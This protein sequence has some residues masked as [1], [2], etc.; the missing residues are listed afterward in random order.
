MAP[1]HLSSTSHRCPNGMRS[2]ES[3]HLE[4]VWITGA[5]LWLS[6]MHQWAFGTYEPVTS[7]FLSL[8]LVGL[9]HC[10]LGTPNETLLWRSARLH[11]GP[12]VKV[13]QILMQTHH[14]LF[15]THQ[16]RG[17][18]VHLWPLSQV[19]LQWDN[20]CY[21]PRLSVVMMVRCVVMWLIDICF[22]TLKRTS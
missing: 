3:G 11:N 6:L 22:D 4:L 19:P 21:S 10:R 9:N 17:Q 18:N 13:A 1:I 2:E 20:W 8:L 16:L 5:L 7:S 12:H 14:F 15:Q